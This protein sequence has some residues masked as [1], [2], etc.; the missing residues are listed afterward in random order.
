M[1][2]L[3]KLSE[4]HYVIVDDSEI[5]DGDYTL[6]DNEKIEVWNYQVYRHYHDLVAFKI[7]HSTEPLEKFICNEGIKRIGWTKIKPL[8]VSEVEDYRDLKI[9]K[10]TIMKLEK[11]K[12]ILTEKDFKDLDLFFTNT[13]LSVDDRLKLNKIILNIIDNAR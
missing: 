12:E 5:K 11:L 6:F 13:N 3:I 9:K 10:Y 8:E 1:N 4:R 7:T 2:K